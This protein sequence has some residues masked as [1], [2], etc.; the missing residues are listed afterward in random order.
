VKRLLKKTQKVVKGMPSA[1]VLSILI[2]AGLFLLAGLLVVFT[3]LPPKETTFEAPKPVKRPKMP[4]RKIQMKVKKPSK[5][6]ASAKITALVKTPDLNEIAFPDLPTGGF[7]TGIGGEGVAPSFVE[8]PEIEEVTLFGDQQPI[9][10]DFTGTF[11]DL[12]RTRNGRTIVMSNE[13]CEVVLDKFLR[14]GWKLSALSKYYR[15]K[16]KLY[17]TCFMIGP[18]WSAFAPG[19][20]GE[21]DVE[22]LLWLVHYKGQLVYPE[23]IKFRFWGNADDVLAVRVEGEMV[24]LS[25]RKHDLT[26]WNY[27]PAGSKIHR[28]GNGTAEIGKWIT[29]EANTP[30]DMEVLIAEIPGGHFNAMLCVEVDGVEYEQNKYGGP[31]L[32]MFKTEEPSRDLIDVIY[33]NLYPGEAS[34]TNGPVFRDY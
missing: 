5:P 19:A 21:P 4:L 2:H 33:Y 30:L 9:G 17:A 7:G 14:S 32:P 13:E 1:V 23:P 26:D 34:V 15:A 27:E 24:F 12:K 29:L 16:Q 6:K 25:D 11:Y 10:N 3:V 22:G 20:F 8:L 28:M 31:I 18:I